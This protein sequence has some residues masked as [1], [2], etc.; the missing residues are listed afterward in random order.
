[1]GTVVRWDDDQGAGLVEL[2]DRPG[3]CRVEAAALDPRAGGGLRAGQIV[4]VEWTDSGA[5]DH[6][7]QASRVTPRDDLQGTPGA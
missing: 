2:T 1:M 7:L 5:G 4:E 6:P 3:D